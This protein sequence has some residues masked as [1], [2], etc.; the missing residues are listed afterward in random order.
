MPR[1]APPFSWRVSGQPH[2]LFS[3]RFTFHDEAERNKIDKIKEAFDGNWLGEINVTYERY[4]YHQRIQ[5]LG[6]AIEDVVADLRKLSKS[7]DFEHLEDSLIRDRI[8]ISIRDDA[9]TVISRS[10]W[11][12][13]S[14]SRGR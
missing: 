14:W 13:M 11:L 12:A 10:R 2:V 8:I 5:Q 6:E 4:V 3:G 9:F 7:C 1:S